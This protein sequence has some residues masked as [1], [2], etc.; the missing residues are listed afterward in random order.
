MGRVIHTLRLEY[1]S[2]DENSRMSTEFKEHME[3]V[4]A[5][6]GANLASAVTRLEEHHASS[7][8]QHEKLIKDAHDHFTEASEKFKSALRQQV[9]VMAKHTD[10]HEEMVERTKILALQARNEFSDVNFASPLEAAGG[11]SSEA[12][13]EAAREEKRARKTATEYLLDKAY[14]D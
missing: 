12:E 9:H 14:E 5:S 7:I 3:S 2:D 13:R 11:P 10:R 1:I 8:E 4:L 6:L